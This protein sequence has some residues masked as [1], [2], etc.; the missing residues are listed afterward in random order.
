MS[1]RT[2]NMELSCPPANPQEGQLFALFA[3]YPSLFPER[4]AEVGRA[5]SVEDKLHLFVLLLVARNGSSPNVLGFGS[6][7]ILPQGG[8]AKSHRANGIKVSQYGS[9]I[10]N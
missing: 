9:R 8:T 10:D 4:E 3:D 1:D 2:V 5:L 7:Y 6:Q